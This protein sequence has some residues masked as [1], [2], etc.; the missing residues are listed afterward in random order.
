MSTATHYDNTKAG[1][2]RTSAETDCRTCR[3]QIFPQSLVQNFPPPSPFFLPQLHCHQPHVS[4][5][6]K[7][8]R[9]STCRI[10][11]QSSIHLCSLKHCTQTLLAENA[12]QHLINQR[13]S[14]IIRL[15]MYSCS[16]AFRNHPPLAL[17]PFR[18][19]RKPCSPYAR[20]NG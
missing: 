14:E 16:K 18:I 2:T 1:V 13:T 5:K 17:Q 4:S 19:P 3:L 11:S 6:D 15:S 9:L 7:Q 12:L 8:Q 10:I 20:S